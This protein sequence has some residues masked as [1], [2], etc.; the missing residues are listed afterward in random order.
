MIKI[1]NFCAKS[2][3]IAAGDNSTILMIHTLIYN[4]TLFKIYS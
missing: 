1:L 4:Y 2:E 3:N